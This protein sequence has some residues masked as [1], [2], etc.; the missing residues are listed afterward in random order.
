MEMIEGEREKDGEGRWGRGK[1]GREMGREGKGHDPEDLAKKC[2]KLRTLGFELLA[3]WLRFHLG[4]FLN[5][6]SL[7]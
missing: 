7:P 3:P 4:T 2:I 1:R 6:T 5:I